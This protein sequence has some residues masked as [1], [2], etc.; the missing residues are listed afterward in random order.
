MFSALNRQTQFLLDEVPKSNTTGFCQRE[1]V[2]VNLRISCLLPRM[3]EEQ[4]LDE[5]YFKKRLKR[6]DC[7][8]LQIIMYS[9]ADEYLVFQKI[10]NTFLHLLKGLCLRSMYR[11]RLGWLTIWS[12]AYHESYPT[13]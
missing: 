7:S 8:Y 6:M 10:R 13:P 12:A 11:L 4:S 1:F 3:G 9:M 2:R 5:K